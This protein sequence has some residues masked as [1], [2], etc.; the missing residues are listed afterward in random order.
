M[1]KKINPED[2]KEGQECYIKVVTEK[3]KTSDGRPVLRDIAGNLY[4]PSRGE[5]IYT[6]EEQSIIS[7]IQEQPIVLTHD[8]H[9]DPELAMLVNVASRLYVSYS[10]LC[11]ISNKDM[12]TMDTCANEASAI[13]AACKRIKEGER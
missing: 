5:P 12:P 2:L 7:T 6:I 13:I 4:Y 3:V 9:P 10:E 1:L 11:E 8:H